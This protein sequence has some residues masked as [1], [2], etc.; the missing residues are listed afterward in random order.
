MSKGVYYDFINIYD[1]TDALT[2]R[3]NP[4]PIGSQI[5]FPS[6]RA[7]CHCF[8]TAWKRKSIRMVVGSRPEVTEGGQRAEVTGGQ[9]PTTILIL[10][11]FQVVG[12]RKKLQTAN[13]RYFLPKIHFSTTYQKM[14][15]LALMVAEIWAISFWRFAYQ[16]CKI[17]QNAS[18]ASEI[19]ESTCLSDVLI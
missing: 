16:F 1:S 5:W 7:Q 12:K 8:P 2:T 11:R 13:Q 3:M 18:F 4:K 14:G 10:L 15:V 9:T 17:I 19:L 6:V